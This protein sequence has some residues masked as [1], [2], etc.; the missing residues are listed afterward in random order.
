MKGGAKDRAVPGTGELLTSHLTLQD[1][2]VDVGRTFMELIE[3]G[4][5]DNVEDN[6]NGTGQT[7]GQ[8]GNIDGIKSFVLADASNGDPDK[9]FP[10]VFWAFIL[11]FKYRAISYII[12]S[13]RTLIRIR[14]GSH[15]TEAYMGAR[16]RTAIAIYWTCTG[17]KCYSEMRDSG[18]VEAFPLHF[19]P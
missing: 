13:T 9:V 16:N 18:F 14:N 19:P 2:P 3:T 15:S 12:L 17:W 6:E 10:H 11:F 7:N 4:F 5:A 8:A 1:Q